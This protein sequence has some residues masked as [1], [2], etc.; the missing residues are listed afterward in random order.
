MIAMWF[1]TAILTY[2]MLAWKEGHRMSWLQD[3]FGTEKPIIAM[4]HLRAMPGDPQYN[5]STGM[6]AVI[7]VARQDLLALQEGGVDAVMFSNE[8]SRPYLTQVDTVTV[9]SMARV[10]GEL[11][12][13]VRVPFGVNVLWDAKASLDL[14]VAVGARF[15]REIFTGAYAS[16]FGI[17]D[18]NCGEV[19]RHQ[20]T[21]GAED[22]RLLFNIYPEAAKYLADRCLGDI[23][24]TTVFNTLPDGLCVSGIT[25]GA[26][27]DVSLLAEV[28]KAVPDTPVFANTGVRVDS[29]EAQMSVADG[30]IVGTYFKVDGVTWNQVD[31]QRVKGFMDVVRAFRR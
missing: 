17:W 6:E 10:I 29:V 5:R 28:K 15:V 21:I 16:D 11:L 25:A 20:H 19:V 7:E 27:T 14:A 23:A 13:E 9:A 31:A 3:L 22:V 8:F 30:A 26:E 18:T 24:K 12:R 1:A 4:C 2:D